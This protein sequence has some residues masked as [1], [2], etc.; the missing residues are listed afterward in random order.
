MEWQGNTV[1]YV[2]NVTDIDDDILRKAKA[3]G[4]DR[5]ALGNRW[6]AHFIEDL[7]LNVRP[8]DDYPRSPPV[9][10][11]RLLHW[12]RHWWKKGVAYA[13]GG[14]VYFAVDAWPDYGKLSHIARS[15]MLPIANERGICP[16]IPTSATHSRILCSGRRR[17]L[18]EPAWD[19]PWGKGRPGWHI[20]CSTMSTSLLGS[21]IDLHSGGSDLLFPHHECE[22][23]QVEGATG[24]EP[25]VR[26][27][28]HTAMV[29]H[30]GEKMSKSLGN[31]VM[32]RDLLQDYTADALRLYMASHHYRHPWHYDAG[33]L[34]VA[35]S[36]AAVGRRP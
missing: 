35:Q 22:I 14:N 29:E 18:V 20:E 10:L 25:F 13:A 24:Q 5:R 8:P 11:Q 31:L 4:E 33:E 1:H 12:W 28:F 23:A 30:E 19:S 32:A 7:S 27:W 26:Y 16:T 6:T 3:V 15:E 34:R 17:P 9:S 36:L 2:Q 21:T